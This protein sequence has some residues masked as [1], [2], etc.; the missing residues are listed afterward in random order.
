MCHQ[1]HI[2]K[3]NLGW[4]FGHQK[5]FLSSDLKICKLVGKRISWSIFR[6]NVTG[7][8]RS[9][10]LLLPKLFFITIF[11]RFQ[12]PQPSSR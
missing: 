1:E 4:C 5:V 8:Y 12:G 3:G 9:Q 7:L 11:Y 10:D 2:L 6:L